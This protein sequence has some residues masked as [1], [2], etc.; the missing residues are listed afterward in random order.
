MGSSKSSASHARAREAI[1]GLWNA[2]AVGAGVRNSVDVGELLR[3][4]A[5]PLDDEH[6]A[7]ISRLLNDIQYVTLDRSSSELDDELLSLYVQ[8]E[9][10]GLDARSLHPNFA[11]RLEQSPALRTSYELLREMLQALGHE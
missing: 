2:T 1:D 8:A 3:L 11:A 6:R 5:Q 7:Q 9:L 10:D 4:L